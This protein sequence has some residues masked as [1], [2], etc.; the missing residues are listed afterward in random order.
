[1][2]LKKEGA[3]LKKEINHSRDVSI[4]LNELPSSVIYDIARYCTNKDVLYAIYEIGIERDDVGFFIHLAENKSPVIRDILEKISYLQIP[5]VQAILLREEFASN[6]Y[7]PPHV[8]EKC[9][10][11][12]FLSPAIY[13][14]NTP[15]EAINSCFPLMFLV[16]DNICED[17]VKA[18]GEK[19][20][21]E[22]LESIIERMPTFDLPRKIL[23]ERRN[24]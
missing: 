11:Y 5:A 9:V 14:P 8:L 3:N 17:V 6:P 1:M 22:V 12:S 7:S 19:L 16:R 18:N 23:A 24:K 4:D 13:N 21:D 20:S 10:S 15:A 2:Q